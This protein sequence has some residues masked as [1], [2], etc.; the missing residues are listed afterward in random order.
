MKYCFL[1]LLLVITTTVPSWAQTTVTPVTPPTEELRNLNWSLPPG[2]P[3]ESQNEAAIRM[4]DEYFAANPGDPR[5]VEA[6]RLAYEGLSEL[7]RGITPEPCPPEQIDRSVTS[8]VLASG[9]DV[10]IPVSEISYDYA[11][12]L[13]RQLAS[14]PSIP[15]GYPEDG[16]YARAHYMAHLL[17]AQGI[18]VGKAFLE[19]NL[20]VESSNS[21]RGVVHWGYHV[22]PV[23]MIRRNGISR[24]YV[25]DPSLFST[26][27]P[28]A[29]WYYAQTSHP[30]ARVNTRYFTSQH[31]YWPRRAGATDRDSYDPADDAQMKITMEEYL[32][33]QTDRRA[34][35]SSR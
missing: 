17:N 20:R 22:A 14:D 3:P 25:I 10:R 27:V 16:C 19:G 30:T 12:E 35:R 18:T 33:E 2:P 8:A 5:L 15:F 1:S 9:P 32:E 28:A 34:R 29:R 4:A 23:V 13:F 31:Q 24:P 21:E 6:V 7:E 11:V 26:P